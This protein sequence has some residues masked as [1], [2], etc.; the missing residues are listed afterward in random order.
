MISYLI[1]CLTHIAQ[2]PKSR[3]AVECFVTTGMVVVGGEVTS[4]AQVDVQS[5]VRQK[6][7][8]IG[9]THPDIGFDA[10]TCAVLVVSNKQSAD[11]AQG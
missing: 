5:L 9:Y 3:V 7:T 6:L 11:I 10:A 4:K 8:D 1:H 2:D